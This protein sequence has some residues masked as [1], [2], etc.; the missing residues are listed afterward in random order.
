LDLFAELQNIGRRPAPFEF[1]TAPVLWTEPHRASQMLSYHLNGELDLASRRTAFI[2]RSAAWM[3]RRFEL[4]P[5]KSVIDFGCGPGLYARRL[6]A[7][8]AQVTGV[9]FSSRSLEFARE[10][11]ASTDYVCANYL[12]FESAQRFDLV[13]MIMCDFCALGPEQRAKLLATFRSLLRPGGVLLFDVYSMAAYEARVESVSFAP[14]LLDGFWSSEPYFGFCHCFK[15]DEQAVVLDKYT[16]IE[17]ERRYEVY[18]WLQSF[19]PQSLAR[20]LDAAGLRVAELLG[21]VAGDP[22]DEAS[23]EFAVLVEAV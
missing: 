6:A 16:I 2:E 3:C 9:D 12:E 17:A 15:Y 10:N 20:E 19:S 13:M 18:N 21:N 22:Y 5:G 1:Y 4:G 23:T 11:D 14:K 8:G 7:S